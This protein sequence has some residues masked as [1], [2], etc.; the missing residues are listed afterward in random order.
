MPAMADY[1]VCYDIADHR[2]LARLHRCLRRH[3]LPIQYSVF[4]LTAGEAGL[5]RCV[6]EASRLIDAKT[7]DL[8]IYSLPKDGLRARLGRALFPE[9]VVYGGM[10]SAW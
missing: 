2:R 8:R 10:P 6:E 1:L 3:A 9:G 7:D 5:R 4:L